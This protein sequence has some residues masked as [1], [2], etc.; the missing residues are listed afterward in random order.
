MPL[1]ISRLLSSDGPDADSHPITSPTHPA[2]VCWWPHRPL[3]RLLGPCAKHLGVSGSSFSSRITVCG[4]GQIM[5]CFSFLD[6]K[7]E[8][9]I[10]CRVAVILNDLLRLGVLDKQEIRYSY[11]YYALFLTPLNRV[12]GSLGQALCTALVIPIEF[13]A[14]AE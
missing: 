8:I 6:W 13:L 4:L 1:L 11:F 5:L 14:S 3:G 12:T 9:K 7:M 2:Q 10:P